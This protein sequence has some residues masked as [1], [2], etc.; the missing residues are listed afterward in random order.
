MLG[1]PRVAHA[2]IFAD[3]GHGVTVGHELETI[4][5][6]QCPLHDH[7]A[8]FVCLDFIDALL[9]GGD[10]GYM[11]TSTLWTTVKDELHERR[12]ARAAEAALRA[13]LANYRTPSDIEDLLASVDSHDTPEAEMIRD[14]LMDNLRTYHQR[15]AFTA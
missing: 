14:V 6:R 11:N 9:V 15:R 2:D 8:W 1:K 12:E 3:L 4:A 5:G 10:T 7:I 13:D